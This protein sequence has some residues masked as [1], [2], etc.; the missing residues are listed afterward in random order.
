MWTLP[1][2]CVAQ[3]G[4]G[5][6]WY[7]TCLTGLFSVREL[8]LWLKADLFGCVAFLG[9]QVLV[10]QILTSLYSDNLNFC[11]VVMWRMRVITYFLQKLPSLGDRDLWITT[12]YYDLCMEKMSVQSEPPISDSHD[13]GT[14]V[15]K[16][17][18]IK[19]TVLKLSV[20]SNILIGL[21]Q[22][23]ANSMMLKMWYLGPQMANVCNPFQRSLCLNT[24]V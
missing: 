22:I 20:K 21:L 14:I 9:S 10:W 2:P 17:W 13:Q 3:P 19:D 15:T 8:T 16:C 6:C 4:S 5:V 1:S 11:A 18:N 7:P 12:D 24:L 23:L